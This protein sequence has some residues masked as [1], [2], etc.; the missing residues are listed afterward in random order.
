MSEFKSELL[1]EI[2]VH[3]QFY[4]VKRIT[5]QELAKWQHCAGTSSKPEAL[6]FFKNVYKWW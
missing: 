5:S 3:N 6:I 2:V 1:D 4:P